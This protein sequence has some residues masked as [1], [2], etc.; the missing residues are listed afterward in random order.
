MAAGKPKNALT[1]HLLYMRVY[2]NN[3]CI[4]VFETMWHE[5]FN[6]MCFFML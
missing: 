2:C 6:S 3:K 4:R 5:K 1:E